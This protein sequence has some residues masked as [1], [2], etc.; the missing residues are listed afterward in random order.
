MH[1][2]MSA[3]QPDNTLA[4][5]V[6][7]FHFQSATWFVRHVRVPTVKSACYPLEGVVLGMVLALCVKVAIVLGLLSSVFGFF[8][9]AGPS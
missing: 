4:S 7:V 2:I 3:L 8:F 6:T 9:S 5:S 1:E